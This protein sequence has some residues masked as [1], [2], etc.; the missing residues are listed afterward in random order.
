[1]AEPSITQIL[2]NA[3]LNFTVNNDQSLR[4][5]HRNSRGDELGTV[6]FNRMPQ[7]KVTKKKKDT[8][9]VERIIEILQ[10]EPAAAQEEKASI[11]P[12]ANKQSSSVDQ[13][14]KGGIKA[15]SVQQFEQEQN[16]REQRI[17]LEDFQTLHQII[18]SF[19]TPPSNTDGFDSPGNKTKKQLVPETKQI[20]QKFFEIKKQIEKEKLTE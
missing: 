8:Q 9:R 16:Q 11:T 20:F 17:L 5:G 15:K 7:I 10:Q 12:K 14:P 2:S 18:E 1:V 6:N 19:G 3:S 13:P 4:L